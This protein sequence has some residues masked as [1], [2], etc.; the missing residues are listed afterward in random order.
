M[1]RKR[2]PDGKRL[3]KAARNPDFISGIYNYCDRWCEKCGF[4][5]RCMVY[6]MEQESRETEADAGG[7][8]NYWDDVQDNLHAAVDLLRDMATERG[9]DL[10]AEDSSAEVIEHDRQRS[11]EHPLAKCAE[12]YAIKMDAWFKTHQDLLNEKR[13]ELISA[14]E[15]GLPGRNPVREAEEIRD[16]LEVINWY[17]FQIAAKVVRALHQEPDDAEDE[18]DADACADD[19]SGSAKVALIGI[20]R[21]LAAW[22]RLREHI[23]Q[24][25]DEILDILVHLDRLRRAIEAEFP[26][27]RG[28]KR[29]GFDE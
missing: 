25:G 1:A 24:E 6:A 3:R 14:D 16:A 11:E 29:P 22:T 18:A 13:G 23:P 15:A 27:A 17:Q 8:D 19:S 10:E 4:T 9:I 20:D 7:K 26:S 12:D 2:R 21:S 28:F 5:S